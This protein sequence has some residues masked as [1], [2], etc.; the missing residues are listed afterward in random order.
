MKKAEYIEKY[1]QAAYEKILEQSRDCQINNPDK[2]KPN[3]PK[4]SPERGQKGGRYYEK[5]LKQNHTGLRYKRGLIRHNH[6]VY[7]RPYKK[8]V[9]PES[10]I[11]HE[12]TPG[13]PDYTGVALVETD[14]HM[15]GYIDIIQILEGKITLLTE[16]EIRNGGGVDQ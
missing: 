12:W 11:H 6:G 14:Q 4:Y 3:N 16:A 1:G 7:Y 8:I 10:Q 15:R 9:A 2:L 5:Y 13:T